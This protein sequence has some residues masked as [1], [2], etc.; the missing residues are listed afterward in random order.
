M[1][2]SGS[3]DNAPPM[4]LEL[5]DVPHLF[6]QRIDALP[7]PVMNDVLSAMDESPGQSHG[8]N[9]FLGPGRSHNGVGTKA[10]RN[11]TDSE[12]RKLLQRRRRDELPADADT[13][14][15]S[16][17]PYDSIPRQV[18]LQWRVFAKLYPEAARD[19]IA[20]LFMTAPGCSSMESSSSRGLSTYQ[21]QLLNP[22]QQHRQQHQHQPL[23]PVSPA[24]ESVW[25][26][27][28]LARAISRASNDGEDQGS[29]S[30]A[31][32]GV[33]PS[34][35]ALQ[36]TLQQLV[37]SPSAG[38]E[39]TLPAHSSQRQS[40]QQHGVTDGHPGRPQQD[41]AGAADVGR[42][43]LQP[44]QQANDRMQAP[45]AMGAAATGNSSSTVS[46][47][48]TAGAVGYM[49]DDPIVR[50]L[51]QSLDGWYDVHWERFRPLRRARRG[52]L[53]AVRG[54]PLP[55]AW[56]SGLRLATPASSSVSVLAMAAAAAPP[57]GLT[58]GAGSNNGGGGGGHGAMAGRMLRW[59]CSAVGTAARAAA[60][61]VGLRCR[62]QVWEVDVG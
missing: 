47:T 24:V 61:A 45:G 5:P 1:H 14:D 55:L 46:V 26:R 41:T 58:A 38:G 36:K 52:R 2:G 48:S 40:E 9:P 23:A 29:S 20:T 62:P 51:S 27:M 43:S 39:V 49:E 42:A 34:A 57:P 22:H 31:L 44:T 54:V 12:L 7:E 60:S 35:S 16:S 30:G 37:D 17:E 15:Y 8:W 25:Q 4:G 56:R 18:Q 19:R 59:C 13:A 28:G 21:Q 53:L 32:F 10:A 33:L 11:R 6:A 50:N 3:P